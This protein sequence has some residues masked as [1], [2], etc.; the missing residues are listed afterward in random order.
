VV[1][2]R[3]EVAAGPQHGAVLVHRHDLQALVADPFGELQG[4]AQLGL[5]HVELLAPAGLHGELGGG[6]R[7]EAG[8]AQVAGQRVGRLGL[9][10]GLRPA[11]EVAEGLRAVEVQAREA[12]VGVVEGEAAAGGGLQRHRA[13]VGGEGLG[14]EGPLDQLAAGLDQV[15]HGLRWV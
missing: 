11:P 2:R 15:R 1:A 10:F 4:P 12:P 8:V 13:V 7:L 14:H 3:L 5:G 6:A 9:G